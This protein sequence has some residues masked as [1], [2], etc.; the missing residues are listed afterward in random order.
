MAVAIEAR[1]LSGRYEAATQRGDRVEWPPHPARVFCALVGAARSHAEREALE[2]L[3]AQPPPQVWAPELEGDSA[4]TTYV[5]TNKKSPKGGHQNW[6]GRTATERTRVTGIPT[7]DTFAL[8][9]GEAE[10]PEGVVAALG[11]AAWRVPYLGRASNPAALRVHTAPTRRDGWAIY[12]PTRLDAVNAIALRVCY[13]GYLQALDAAF[14]EG[15][16]AWEESRTLPYTRES[17]DDPAPEA[18]TAAGPFARILAFSLPGGTVRPEGIDLLRATNT[19]R[20]T[21]LSRIGDAAAGQITGHTDPGRG[22]VGYIGLV[23]VGHANARGHLL[24][25]GVLLP[26][27]LDTDAAVQLRHALTGEEGVRVKMGRAG[28]LDLTYEPWPSTPR[29][30][31]PG[32]WSAG[33]GGACCWSSATPLMLDRY[34]RPSTDRAAEVA[35]CLV[36]AGY[37][38]PVRVEVGDAPLLAGAPHRMNPKTFPQN[39]PRRKM[40]HARITF[41]HPVRG[42]VAAGSLRYLG[43]GLF[44]PAPAHHHTHDDEDA[45]LREAAHDVGR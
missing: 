7:D 25:M 19:L 42:P 20:A 21:V 43:L 13:P 8:V 30:L 36:T 14:D 41:P 10:P 12:R 17:D 1:L 5:V 2:W 38:E 28:H 27:D 9:W 40:L 18:P 45:Q 23:D 4:V 35:R 39:R 37:P 3:E 24:G 33:A 6:P 32:Y 22:H 16:R 29:R 15:R 31:T 11:E 26:E 34:I 44:A